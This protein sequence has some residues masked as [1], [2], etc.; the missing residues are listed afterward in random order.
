VNEGQRWRFRLRVEPLPDETYRL[1]LL[2]QLPATNGRRPQVRP[3]GRLQGTP[4]LV[5]LDQVLE[6]LRAEGYRRLWP[7]AAGTSG[8]HEL[9]L[10]EASGVRL[11]VLFLALRPVP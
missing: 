3:I 2:Q 8:R 9:E 1:T 11:G 7:R 4:L 5:A 6:L 10:E